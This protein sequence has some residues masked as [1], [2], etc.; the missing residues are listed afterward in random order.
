MPNL[1][2]TFSDE[3]NNASR[4]ID[5]MCIRRRKEKK[6]TNLIAY[7]GLNHVDVIVETILVKCFVLFNQYTANGH[8]YRVSNFSSVC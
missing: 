3:I 4:S 1:K 7:I 2:C 6:N 5:S 8:A